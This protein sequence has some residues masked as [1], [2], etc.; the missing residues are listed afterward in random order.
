VKN[1][2]LV[3]A[4][5][6]LPTISPFYGV[7]PSISWHCV[8]DIWRYEKKKWKNET[9]ESVKWLNGAKLEDLDALFIWIGQVNVKNATAGDEVTV[10]PRYT[11]NRFESFCLYKMHKLTPVF[12][13]TSQFSLIRAPSSHKLTVVPGASPRK[14]MG[15]SFSFY[16]F[17]PY[18]QFWRN[19]LSS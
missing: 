13:F 1:N 17:S 15:N 10:I 4:S 16:E 9:C 8:G 11:S 6:I 14:V 2:I 5:K 3:Q 7:N 19:K 18:E 12:Q